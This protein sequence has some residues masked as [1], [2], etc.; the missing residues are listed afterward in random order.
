MA[1]PPCFSRALAES[2]SNRDGRAERLRMTRVGEEGIGLHRSSL[3]TTK[4]KRI[5]RLGLIKRWCSGECPCGFQKTQVSV[6]TLWCPCCVTPGKQITSPFWVS[7]SSIVNERK[8]PSHS[9]SGKF[10]AER[11]GEALEGVPACRRLLSS[12]SGP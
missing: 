10:T 6:W 2:C 3:K 7:V 5:C 1:M 12:C 11:V 9:C 4:K 8:W